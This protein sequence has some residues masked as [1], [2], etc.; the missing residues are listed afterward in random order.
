MFE[1]WKHLEEV[2]TALQLH[3]I[4]FCVAPMKTAFMSVLI[5]CKLLMHFCHK[6]LVGCTVFA[7]NR[8]EVGAKYYL[9]ISQCIG[10]QPGL[11]MV[12]RFIL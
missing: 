11:C 9:Q 6:G 5:F 2:S 3:L 10:Q 8:V 12:D 7:N 4:T 1:T